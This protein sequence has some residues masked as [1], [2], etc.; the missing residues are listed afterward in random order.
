MEKAAFLLAD[1]QLDSG[2]EEISHKLL[3]Q[4]R[5]NQQYWSLVMP[6]LRALLGAAD[7]LMKGGQKGQ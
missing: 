5:G 7:A 2:C 3:E 4:H 1:S 6:P